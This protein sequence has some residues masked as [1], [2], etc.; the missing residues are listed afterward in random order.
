MTLPQHIQD[1]FHERKISDRTLEEFSIGWDGVRIVYPIFDTAGNQLFC[2]YRRD[3]ESSVGPKYYY[4]KG[5]HVSLYGIHR[6]QN[7]K[8]VLIVEGLNDF[9]VAWSAGIPAVT[10]TGGALSFQREWK[11][12]FTD[13]DVTICLDGDEAGA[14]GTV[15]ILSILPDAHVILLPEG[16]KDISDL[17]AGGDDL[18]ELMKTRKHFN[19][20]EEVMADKAERMAGYESVLFHEAY[21]EAQYTPEI[22]PRTMP[23]GDDLARAKSYPITNLLKFNYQKKALCPYHNETTPS[24]YYNEENNTGHCFG[25]GKH[26]DVIDVFMTMNNCGFKEAVEKLQ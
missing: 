20:L 26:V 8:S 9:L 12:V 14:K 16:I 19:N 3:P 10:S 13:K 15:K 21:E 24:F 4:E 17:V 6:I 11:D 22:T 25:C 5:S 7:E 2:C 23:V 1:F 18:Q